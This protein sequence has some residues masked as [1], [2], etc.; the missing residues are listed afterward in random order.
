VIC[1]QGGAEFGTD[2]AVMDADLLHRARASGID[3][4]VVITALA[5]APGREYDTANRNGVTHFG[6]L[7]RREGIDLDVVAAPDSRKDR[8]AAVELISS[9]SMLVLP[10]GSPS[11][12]L[13]A[14]RAAGLDAVIADLVSAGAVVMGASAG[15]M[16]MCERTWL[17]DAGRISDGVGL[18]PGCLVLPHWSDGGVSRLARFGGAGEGISVLG[19][20]EQ[21]GLLVE[22]TSGGLTVTAVGH[23][24]SVVTDPTGQART[25]PL[26]GSIDLPGRMSR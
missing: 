14:L 3:G 8:A 17:P 24:P 2:G 15:A 1:L 22:T 19:L 7:A 9:A 21:S 26:G 5:G 10:G 23:I 6:A 18:V 4:P 25:I 20:P 13:D 12:L 11:R 16:V